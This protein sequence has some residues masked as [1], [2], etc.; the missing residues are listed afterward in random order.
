ML[1]RGASSAFSRVTKERRVKC[2][3]ATEG[4]DRA[5]GLV[6]VQDGE[7]A[8]ERKIQNVVVLACVNLV[9]VDGLKHCCQW[10]FYARS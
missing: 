9:A 1:K 5:C 3:V 2:T 10:P 8:L 6:V 4:A 7:I